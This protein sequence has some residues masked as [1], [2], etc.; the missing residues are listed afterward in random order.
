MKKKELILYGALLLIGLGFLYLAG[1]SYLDTKKMLKNG[2]RTTAEVVHLKVDD[3]I[4]YPVMK[5][6]ANGNTHT[7]VSEIGTSWPDYKIGDKVNIVY[8]KNDV[9]SPKI[10]TYWGLYFGCIISLLFALPMITVSGG[11]FLF[12]AGIL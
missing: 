2:I 1:G 8:D 12:K 3:N 10:I 4:Y 7:F 11:F 5:Y 9:G 6:E